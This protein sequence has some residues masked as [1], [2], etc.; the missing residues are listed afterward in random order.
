MTELLLQIEPNAATP[1]YRQVYNG[2]RDVILAG[3]LKAGDR[4]PSSR[5]FA[6]RL[7]VG[8]NTVLEAYSQLLAEGY[9]VTSAGAGTFVTGDIPD[10]LLRTTQDEDEGHRT[11]ELGM[12]DLSEFGRRIVSLPPAPKAAWRRLAPFYPGI[13]A[14][15]LFPAAV[16]RKLTADLW[17]TPLESDLLDYGE[18]QGYEPLRRAIVEYTGL[19]RGVSCT[20][21]QV[22]ITGGS[23][24]ALSLAS[25]L[26]LDPGDEVWIE[27]PGYR[28]ARSAFA[29]AGARVVPV[30]VDAEGLVVSE[31]RERA[32]RPRLAYITPSHQFPLGHTMSISRRLELL[33]YASTSRMWVIEDDYDSE[34]RYSGR[35]LPALHGLDRAQRVIYMGTFSKVLFPSLRVGYLIVPP[36]LVEAFVAARSG[37]DR[38]RPTLDQAVLAKFIADG[39]FE[40]HLRRMRAAYL[41]RQKL[42]V[43]RL[44]ARVGDVLEIDASPAGMHLLAW[45]PAGVSDS[46]VSARCAEAGI[47]ASPLSYYSIEPPARGALVLGYTGFSEPAIRYRARVLADSLRSC[48]SELSQGASPVS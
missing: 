33:D 16:W 43:D 14:Y 32:S 1:L 36:P 30:P 10:H 29:A 27:D 38:H 26:L 4:L 15:D 8:R 44:S 13:P 24:Q 3:R 22:I 41:T 2:L 12:H 48:L 7:G 28:G 40:R 5:A 34:F 19:S 23:Q 25:Q 20:P 18:P 46:H 37:A 45:L 21:D 9:V 35:P 11:T 39:H 6:D 31:G 42:L 17:R 47:A